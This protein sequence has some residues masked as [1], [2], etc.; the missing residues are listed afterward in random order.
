MS[1]SDVVIVALTPLSAGLVALALFPTA[2]VG[3][4]AILG[5]PHRP[6][7]AQHQD[8]RFRIVVPAHNESAGIASTVES[9]LAV[10]WPRDRF[11]V[12]V[13][14]DNCSDDTAAIAEA[15]GATV[16]VRH[17]AELR[18]K[19]YALE[20]AFETLLKRDDVD[21]IVVV[22]ADTVVTDNLLDAFAARIESGALAM[23]AE[24][25]VRNVDASWRTQ[26]MAFALGMFHATRNNARE[27]LGL[28]A[29]LRGNG[30]C[31][32]RTCL[33]RF[34]HKAYGLVEDVEYGLALGRGGVRIYA[35]TDAVVRGEMVSGGKASESQRRRWEDGRLQLKR[36]VLPGV[37]KDALKTRSAVL[38]D[39]GL[40]VLMPPLSSVGLLVGLAV[41]IGA[42]RAVVFHVV[43][44]LP[45]DALSVL[46]LLPPWLLSL[47]VLRGMQLSGLGWRAPLVLA[48]APVYVLWKIGLK[49]KGTPKADGWVRTARESEGSASSTKESAPQTPGAGD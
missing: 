4:M 36:D 27:R 39:L 25:S 48:K 32:T 46:V 21:A 29:G 18:G 43:L 49:L 41:V 47:Y 44:Q 8:L 45:V 17:N 23:Q 20:L 26:L 19:G 16:L 38:L 11:E 22:D 42:A 37:L 6:R 40:D 3:L 2:Y 13:V 34:P 12:V 28:S 9:L 1:V 15:A 14:A 10:R 35:V 31:F 30:M 24:Y 7:Q 33:E 5:W